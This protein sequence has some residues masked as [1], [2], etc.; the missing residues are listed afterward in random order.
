[1]SHRPQFC[2]S[3][4]AKI[5]TE[6]ILRKLGVGKVGCQNW[7]SPIKTVLKTLL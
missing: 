4:F 3:A 1:M 2:K 7:D 5:D 6:F